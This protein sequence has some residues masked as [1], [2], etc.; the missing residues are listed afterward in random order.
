MRGQGAE[1]IRILLV[2]DE[3]GYLEVLEKRMTRRGLQV[4]SAG[5]GSEAIR[6]ARAQS[7]DVAVVDLKMEDMDGIEVLKVLKVMDPSMAV[8]ILTGHGSEQAAREGTALGAFDYLTKPCELRDLLAC[9]HASQ[10]S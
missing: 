8:I 6:Q 4:V 9:I 7:F 1:G 3:P 10:K 5:S 2:D